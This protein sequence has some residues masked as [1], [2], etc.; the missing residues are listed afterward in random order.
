MSR[1][2]SRPERYGRTS[3]GASAVPLRPRADPGR[4]LGLWRAGPVAGHGLRLRRLRLRG[5]SRATRSRIVFARPGAIAV[6][7]SASV[8]SFA[9]AAP[10]VR[11]YARALRPRIAP[12]WSASALASQRVRPHLSTAHAVGRRGDWRF[13]G[14]A[15]AHPRRRQQLG[16]M[17]RS[18]GHRAPLMCPPIGDCPAPQAGQRRSGARAGSGVTPLTRPARATVRRQDMRRVAMMLAEP[19]CR[20]ILMGSTAK[21]GCRTQVGTDATCVTRAIWPS[22]EIRS[23]AI[24]PSCVS[25]RTTRRALVRQEVALAVYDEAAMHSR[26]GLN[27]MDVLADQRGHQVA[28]HDRPGSLR[29]TRSAG[30]GIRPPSGC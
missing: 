26:Y 2:R 9:A 6:L 16:C 10:V 19:R 8:Y 24:S 23:S 20:P 27:H 15:V 18:S 14:E 7:R 11:R 21:S 17:G 13:Y 29:W 4:A 1:W 28:A 12:P 25:R 5:V 22:T 30:S 3:V